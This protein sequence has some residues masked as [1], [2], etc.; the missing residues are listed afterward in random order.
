MM[1]TLV[2][3]AALTLGLAFLGAIALDL[4]TGAP[5]AAHAHPG[6]TDGNGWHTCRT[7]CT[8]R[9]GIRYGFYHRHNPVRPCFEPTPTN[10]PRRP[11]PTNTRPPPPTATPVPTAS[12]TNAAT[13]TETA[14]PTETPELSAAD[15][16]ADGDDDASLSETAAGAVA[17]VV[18]G[19]AVIGGGWWAWR[20][21]FRRS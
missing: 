16:T 7:N 2:V 8:E 1:K 15:E 18:L 21:W 5:D 14:L 3:L 19:G 6:N 10:T 4:A 13:P 11:S 20:R 12:A 17:L 9:W